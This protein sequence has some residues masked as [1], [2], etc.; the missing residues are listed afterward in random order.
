MSYAYLKLY[1]TK[2]EPK[3]FENLMKTVI[4]VFS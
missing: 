3:Y 1:K 4:L 2:K